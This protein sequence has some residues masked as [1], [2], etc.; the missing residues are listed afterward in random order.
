MRHIFKIAVYHNNECMGIITA[1]KSLIARIAG[2]MSRPERIIRLERNDTL[3]QKGDDTC[4]EVYFI[5]KHQ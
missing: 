5:E 4:S 1:Y 2:H 3:T